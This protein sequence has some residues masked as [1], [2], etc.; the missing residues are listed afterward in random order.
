MRCK[1]ML[2]DDEY[3]VLE[4]LKK[5]IDWERFDMSITA[6][7]TDAFTALRL[8]RDEP[9]DVLVT[10]IR[11]PNMTG[12][13][14]AEQARAMNPEMNVVFLSGYESFQYAKRAIEL[15][16]GAYILKPIRY[17]EL[18]KVLDGIA[19]DRRRKKL[20]RELESKYIDAFPYLRNELL[21]RWLKG[22]ASLDTVTA[23]LDERLSFPPEGR[24]RAVILE[25]DDISGKPHLQQRSEE[26]PSPA[27]DPVGTLERQ[28]AELRIAAFCRTEP[29]RLACVTEEGT[30][31]WASQEWV[32]LLLDRFRRETGLSFTA[33]IGGQA[34]DLTAVP[35]SYAEAKSALESKM[36]RGKGRV[37]LYEP[38]LAEGRKEH[39]QL[40][41]LDSR[42]QELFDAMYAYDLVSVYD[43]LEELFRYARELRNRLLVYPFLLHIVTK[44]M[45]YLAGKG[46]DLFSLMNW[47]YDELHVLQRMETLDDIERWLRSRIYAC[48]EVLKAKKGRKQ[49][50]VIERIRRYV[51]EHLG[52]PI[53]LR[54]AA[55]HFMLSPNYLGYLFKE[56]TGE[57][58][59]EY[60]A[61]RKM[62]L[63]KELLDDPTLKIYQVA[64]RLG[65]RN[66]S[67]FHN[68]FR[69]HHGVSPGDYRKGKG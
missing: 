45:E 32:D 56:E 3:L 52:Q 6:E 54:E 65:F 62:E 38:G 42:L 69:E 39:L 14:L 61:R 28:L 43:R 20:T 36:F 1:V 34:E 66:M 10:D 51:E 15:E 33:G 21:E 19:R 41:G 40:T 8:L 30:G 4:G 63:A 16:A 24:Y 50:I 17:A 12:L 37:I 9:V 11:M 48:S 60:V 68:Q 5:L 26:Y 18:E 13:E 35:R 31:G 57:P 67:Y 64:D 2:V 49:H 7:C 47:N 27:L 59:T 55:T 44:W 29:H 23:H 25:I 46:E 53:T 22:E 58:F